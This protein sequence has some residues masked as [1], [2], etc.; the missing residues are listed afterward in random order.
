M[1]SGM[2]P[3]LDVVQSGAG[4]S[5]TLARPAVEAG[6]ATLARQWRRTI[7]TVECR[8][9]TLF[10][11][12]PDLATRIRGAWGRQL[13][14]R[15]DGVLPD[16]AAPGDAA[17]RE[18][19]SVL[20]EPLGM[21]AAGLEIPRPYVI[22]AEAKGS[23][24][25]IA[26]TLFGI[27]GRWIEPARAALLEALAGGIRLRH[28]GGVRVPLAPDE[29]RTERSEGVL[30]PD[31]AHAVRLRFETPLVLR[32]GRAAK[33]DLRALLPSLGNRVSGLARWHDMALRHDWPSFAAQAAALEVADAAMRPVGWVRHSARQRGIGIPMQGL[34]GSLVISGDLAPFLALLALGET[35]HAGSHTALGLGRYSLEVLE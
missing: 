16:D 23:G 18:A 10:E 21:A 11:E 1:M 19:L 6:L 35:C 9:P 20:F 4:I 28:D 26:L 17:G 30:A 25:T 8:R 31:E 15:Q 7:V 34:S 22:A 24:I 2:S 13:R 3:P 29:V 32:R 27:A 33:T 12:V 14:A 5:A